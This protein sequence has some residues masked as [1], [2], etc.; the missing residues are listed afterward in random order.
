METVRSLAGRKTVILISHRLANVEDADCIYVMEKGRIAE[1]GTH[2]TLMQQNG[3]YANL[4]L[5][6]Q[7]LEQ[8]GG[9]SEKVD[10]ESVV[11]E[12]DAFSSEADRLRGGVA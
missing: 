11:A 8:F 4:Y 2:S 5:S 1:S 7:E 3:V 9:V 12:S 10:V 6:Q